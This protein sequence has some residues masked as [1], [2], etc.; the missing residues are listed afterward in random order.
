MASPSEA[1]DG[2]RG[3]LLIASSQAR[4]SWGRARSGRNPFCIE[5]AYASVT[6]DGDD[7][8]IGPAGAE[9]ID[10]LENRK[11]Y[12]PCNQVTARHCIRRSVP[13]T[14]LWGSTPF[15]EALRRID[16]RCVFHSSRALASN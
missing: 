7:V 9:A 13:G 1:A 10:A 6:G 3:R 5:G 8:L 16:Q 15:L 4:S 2:H 14:V 11:H 12:N